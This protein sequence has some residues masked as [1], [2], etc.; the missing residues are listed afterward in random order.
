[1][2]FH[3]ID[4]NN[5]IKQFNSNAK[6]GLTGSMVVESRNKYGENVLIKK[7]PKRLI[8]KIFDALKEPMLI[9][10]LFSFVIAFGVCLGQFLKT[11]KGDFAECFGIL[12]AIV[13]SVLITLIME[14]S[15]EK[16]FLTLNK[17]YDNVTL[18]VI[19]DGK[20]VIISQRELVVGDIVVLES[21]DKVL[22]DGRLVEVND[23]SIDESA[24]T[25]ESG[26]VQKSIEPLANKSL[27]LAERRNM[28]Y[29]GTFILSGSG[30]M[31]VTAIGNMTEIGN[32]AKELDS[33]NEVNSPLQQKLNKLSKT[34]T[35]IGCVF[36]FL[37]FA[38]SVTKLIITKNVTFNSVQDLFISCIILIVAVVPEGL[39]TIVAVSLALN[40]IKLAKNNALIKK[41]MATETA[42]AVSVIC[43]DKTG[44][45]TE[46]KMSVVSVCLN[47]FC[48]TPDK[49]TNELLLQNFFCNTTADIVNN[50][51]EKTYQGSKT[52]CA[53]LDAGMKRNANY[54]EYRDKYRIINRV[55]FSSDNKFMITDIDYNGTSRSLI[56]GAPEK[57]IPM[58]NLTEIQK[59]KLTKDIEK[60]QKQAKR[61]L[62]FAHKDG[63]EN[64]YVFDGYTV[65]ADSIRRDVYQA[66]KDCKRAGIS[67]KILTGDNFLTAYAIA[68][69]LRIAETE[70]Q[71]INAVDLDK[72]TDEQLKKILPKITVISRSTPLVKLRIVRLLKS[73]GEVVAVTGDGINDA[74]AIKHADIG[75]AMGISGSEITKESAD[76]VLLDDSFTTITR[77]I[78]FGRNVY[79]N[80]QRF[81]L[82][83]LSVNI[84][85]L[86]FITVIAI[87]G[88]ETP[89]NTLQLLW[90]NVIM[91]GPPA[92]TLGLELGGSSLMKLKPVKRSDSIVSKKMILRIA[93]N[94]FFMASVLL[95]QY[96]TNFL[97]ATVMERNSVIFTLFIMFQ[98]FNAFNSRELGSESILK[99]IG[100]NKVM[101][102]TFICTFIIQILIVQ[103]AY[104]LFGIHPMSFSVWLKTVLT[105]FSIVVISEVYK[106][107]YRLIKG[108]K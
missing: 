29:S 31:I 50:G 48:V 69:E 75:I 101:V 62:C 66:V 63:D 13:L 83:Q 53:L 72:L 28:A 85:A 88:L 45:L 92:L 11:G 58:L 80:L 5:I 82:F 40:M 77:A 49:I 2:D 20:P 86:L 4:V 35:I 59:N 43:S 94:A 68:K 39:P 95:Y 97:G 103:F 93:F 25:G 37:V 105:A 30:K 99:H 46:N 81:I 55:P 36:A 15:S 70:N 65:I 27:P 78:F 1:M 14:G 3:T 64:K 89:F 108:K 54:K 34:I 18:K 8:T 12:F 74:P 9:I 10:L 61:V 21:G 100:K 90:I 6:K 102:L 84:T 104:K 47:E 16:A 87:L 38:L 22:A 107:C 26:A 23:L 32:I 44:T 41:M 42:G 33:K 60:N 106:L 56:K 96:F 91:D 73:M 57:I 76:V 19:R 71:V 7:K 51:K 79:K 17:I 98:L 24:L 67:I 52:E